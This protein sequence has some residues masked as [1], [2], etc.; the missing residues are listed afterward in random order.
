MQYLILCTGVIS[1]GEGAGGQRHRVREMWPP[2]V[3][4]RRLGVDPPSLSREGAL[5][6]RGCWHALGH[7]TMPLVRLCVYAIWR[8]SPRGGRLALTRRLRVPQENRRPPQCEIRAP[9]SKYAPLPPAS[10][11][12]H[13]DPQRPRRRWRSRCSTSDFQQ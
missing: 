6:K 7:Q 10:K 12:L 1:Q 13:A 3:A 2:H 8:P 5:G 4:L 9:T 11:A